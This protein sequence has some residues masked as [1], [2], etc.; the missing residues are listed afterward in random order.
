MAPVSFTQERLAPFHVERDAALDWSA[1]RD[2]G[3]LHDQALSACG[4]E[5]STAATVY[6]K[7]T[8]VPPEMADMDSDENFDR[9][10][11]ACV[12]SL[13][14]T[15]PASMTAQ[16]GLTKGELEALISRTFVDSEFAV[17]QEDESARAAGVD[18]DEIE[19][20]RDLLSANRST[21]GDCGH[22]LAAMVARRALEPNHLWEDLGLRNR[23]ELTRLLERH[24]R[25]LAVRNDK[26]MRWKRFIYRVMCEADGFVMC[27][28]PVCSNCADYNHCFG[29]ENGLSRVA[30]GGASKTTM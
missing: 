20:V 7:L 14:A 17:P 8:G 23:A 22:W 27:S 3:R 18:E 5:T 16:T 24:F 12:L 2:V 29:E 26:N 9:H 10:V 19:S 1:D 15:G 6:R 25:P 21:Q 13:A 4:S 11:L 28:T 30:S